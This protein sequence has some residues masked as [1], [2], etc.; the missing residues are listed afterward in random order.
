MG[1]PRIKHYSFYTDF[2]E[3]GEIPEF[4]IDDQTTPCS[5]SYSNDIFNGRINVV[6]CIPPFVPEHC[7]VVKHGIKAYTKSYRFGYAM[8]LPEFSNTSEFLRNQLGKKPFKNLRQDHQRLKRDYKIHTKVFYGHIDLEIYDELFLKLEEFIHD[9]FSKN[10]RKHFALDRWSFY[11]E[12]AY[13]MIHENKASFFVI[14]NDREPISISLA[15]HY[16]NIMIAT[17]TSFDNAFYHYSLGRQMFV[18]QLN[19]C[20]ENGID[21]IDMGWGDFD[22]KIKFANAVYRYQ[23]QIIYPANNLFLQIGAFFLSWVLLLKTQVAT[24]RKL[25]NKS[26]KKLFEGRLDKLEKFTLLT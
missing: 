7:R 22:Y 10:N 24:F 21:L 23:T 15:Y 12:N 8:Y 18:E 13:Q 5:I 6:N 9:R 26:P 20:Y 11:K 14:Y 19:W 17:V 4:Y 16:R 2:F 3:K 1:I 25:G